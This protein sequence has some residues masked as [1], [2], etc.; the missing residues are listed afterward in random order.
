M[1][2]RPPSNEHRTPERRGAPRVRLLSHAFF[3]AGRVEGRGTLYDLS[4]T[5]AGLKEATPLMKLGTKIR[6][7]FALREDDSPIRIWGKVIRET[8]TG[9]AV[10]FIEQDRRLNEWLQLVISQS[11]S[12]AS[13]Q[14]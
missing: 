1:A 14:P 10:Q 4:I 5:G 13:D 2:P 7:T 8:E 3:S 9:F 12:G 11:E 6:L